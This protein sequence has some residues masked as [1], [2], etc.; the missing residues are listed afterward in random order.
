M[1]TPIRAK[2]TPC[3][4]VYCTT[5]LAAVGTVGR[6]RHALE[7]GG[8]QQRGGA[9]RPP[10]GR[11][12]DEEPDR[13]ERGADQAGDDAFAKVAG[14]GGHGDPPFQVRS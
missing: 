13:D 8:A 1:S 3:S 5:R 11:V 9:E 12:V 6:I 7:R 14:I 2:T 4:T 10:A